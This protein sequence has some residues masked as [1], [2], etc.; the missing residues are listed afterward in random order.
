MREESAWNGKWGLQGD[1]ELVLMRL[2]MNPTSL[3][4]GAERQPVMG[5]GLRF[6]RVSLR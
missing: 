6:G 3:E 4:L 1:Y 2:T 5:F